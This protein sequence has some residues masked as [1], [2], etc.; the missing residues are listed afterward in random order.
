MKLLIVED[1]RTVAD[2]YI[3]L[4]G[5]I[6]DTIQ[7]VTTLEE[8]DTA[9]TDGF[10]PDVVLFDLVGGEQAAIEEI[11]AIRTINPEAVIIVV[12]GHS[13]PAVVQKALE[14]GADY[15]AIKP[16]VDTRE[17]MIAAILTA[18]KNHD[19][20]GRITLIEKLTE[21]ISKKTSQRLDVPPKSTSTNPIK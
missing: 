6:C 3:R 18:A 4:L 20:T 15:Y 5:P 11:K 13:N 10:G 1:E 21:N 12:S 14:R 2:L 9:L 19:P 7:V 16:D 8:V 17:K